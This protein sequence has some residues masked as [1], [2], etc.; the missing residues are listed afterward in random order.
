M[1]TNRIICGKFYN[2]AEPLPLGD[3][4]KWL[5]SNLPDP[6]RERGR[7]TVWGAALNKCSC[8][9]VYAGPT[10]AADDNFKETKI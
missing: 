5:S 7:Q 10:P 1:L 9:S 4:R 6:T 8:R 2:R 3:F